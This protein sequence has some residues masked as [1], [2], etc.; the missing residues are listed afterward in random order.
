M[1]LYIKNMV[2]NRCIMVVKAELERLG[3][4]PSQVELGEVT[5]AQELSPA[6]RATVD[7][8]L[9]GLGFA[10]IDD[11]K[12]RL[13]EKIKTLIVELVHQHS[14]AL[15]INLSGHLSDQ[16]HVDYNYLSHLFSATTWTVMLT[17][18]SPRPTG[19]GP[20][21]ASH[22]TRRCHR[23]RYGRRSRPRVSGFAP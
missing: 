12:S 23:C 11:K 3:Y 18:G 20:G 8:A 17:R 15:K 10:L 4:P 21:S 7:Q 19:C 2:C 22:C 6:E 5:L 13:I 1:K 14:N 9:Q 16:L